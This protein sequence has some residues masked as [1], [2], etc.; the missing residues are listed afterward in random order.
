MSILKL[1]GKH[2]FDADTTIILASAFDAAWL[3]LQVSDS[4][5]A[6]DSRAIETR[7]LLAQRVIEA[8]QR[9]ERD[10]RRLVAEALGQF[11]NST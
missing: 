9:G 7:D 6:A 3:S 2:T 5:L 4:P 8:A 10:K 1:L 11:V